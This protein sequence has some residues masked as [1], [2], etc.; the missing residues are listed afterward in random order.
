MEISKEFANREVKLLQM[1]T[2]NP[3]RN[4]LQMRY[5]Y[6]QGNFEFIVLELMP[7]SLAD[8]LAACPRG[9]R[10]N[11]ADLMQYVAQLAAA[12]MHIHSFSV[13]HRD[14][15][16]A[17]VL[18]DPHTKLIKLADFGSAKQ[19]VE[20][21]P[22]VTYITSRFYRAPETLLDNERYTTKIDIW[23]YGCIVGEL[24]AGAPLFRGESTVDQ[25]M[26]VMRKLGQPCIPELLEINPA[27]NPN[28]L[29]MY[30]QEPESRS[31]RM[32][33]H[34]SK[35]EPSF[36]EFMRGVLAWSPVRRF[37]AQ[38]CSAHEWLSTAPGSNPGSAASSHQGSTQASPAAPSSPRRG[39]PPLRPN[40]R[41]QSP[42][43]LPRQELHQLAAGLQST[44]L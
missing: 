41:H 44:Y 20:G 6:T 5:S 39:L 34:T 4:V 42:V 18:V 11:R 35:L 1:F 40:S 43:P 28:D 16:P 7:G 10:L 27:L 30:P 37:S 32:L 36:E 29:S 8:L 21:K 24:V 13:A 9:R 31:F 3:H 23:A 17:N 12:L 14:L 2:K 22:N 33:L 19:L 26:A 15:K 38:Q 25:L